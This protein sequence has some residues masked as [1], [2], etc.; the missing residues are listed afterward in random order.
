MANNLT[1]YNVSELVERAYREGSPTVE[2]E[3]NGQL[4]R[5]DLRTGIQTNIHLL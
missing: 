2:Y 1:A 3:T 4:Y 5:I